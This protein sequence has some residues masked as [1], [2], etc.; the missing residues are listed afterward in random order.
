MTVSIVTGRLYSGTRLS[1]E[2][3]GL[4]GPVGCADGSHVVSAADHSTLFHHGIRGDHA[5]VVR[6]VLLRHGAAGFL[7]A[8]DA[9]V[10]DDVGVPYLSYVR[11]W[12]N[13]VRRAD[14]LGDH[15]LWRADDGIT[16]LVA[17]GTEEQI[18]RTH[19][20]LESRLGEAGQVVKFAIRRVPGVWGLVARAAGGTKGSALK[21]IAE[22]HGMHIDETVCVGDWYNDTPM[23]AVAGRAYAMG[24]APD[25]VKQTATD[26]LEETSELG[27]G[28]ARVIKDVF[29][30]RA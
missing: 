20:D 15:D 21:W 10:H 14:R 28:I 4:R 19:D 17:V 22:H 26:V 29:G 16:A 6:D 27:G 8:G 11:T 3:I 12:S 2:R 5:L 7:F 30:I 18:A 25:D 24:H 23:L 9:I 1:A 13:D